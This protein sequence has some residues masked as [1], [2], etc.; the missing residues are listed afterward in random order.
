MEPIDI[1]ALYLSVNVLIIV[2]LSV[3]IVGGRFSK[4]I[5]LGSGG[6]KDM[7]VRIRSQGNAI[8]YIPIAMIAL[9]AISQLGAP[10]WLLHSLGGLFTLGRL[11]H[12]IGMAGPLIARQ[13]GTVFTWT[14]LIGFSGAL[15]WFAIS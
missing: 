7:E 9:F 15:F 4:K 5:S 12:P 3:R 8:E 11:I 10:S 6:D 2:V 1:F 14:A 13:L